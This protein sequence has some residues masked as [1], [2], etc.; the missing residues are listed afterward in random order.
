VLSTLVSTHPEYS[1]TVLLRNIPPDFTTTY[2]NVKILEGEYDSREIITAAASE[3]NIVI[4]N[5]NS[6]HEPSINALIAGLLLQSSP[7]FL[8]HLG[9]TGIVADWK[10][11]THRGELN[12]KIWSDID[13]IDA[14]WNLP[15]DALHRNV[16]K[17]IQAAAEKH[18]D[19][20]H[21][22]IICPPDIYGQG[23]GLARNQ[24]VYFPTLYA[25]S[26]KLGRTFYASSGTNT[27][28][29]V[30]ISDLMTVYTRLVEAAA[31]GGANADW[32]LKGYYFCGSQEANQYDLAVAAGKVLKKLGV[33]EEEEPKNC[34]LEVVGG[35]L[36]QYGRDGIALYMYAANSRT[37]ADRAGRVLGYKPV[38]PS[39]W[40][41]VEGD[42]VACQREKQR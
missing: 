7:T 37:R 40:E 29:W 27:R 3:A 42:L 24:S 21:T 11:D 8:L 19:K 34:S 25:E 22:A 2:P 26:S 28:S 31:N 10:S 9:G 36:G 41:C 30:H 6:D 32:G 17:I 15:D 14:I 38:G 39:I 4:H 13:D 20:L 23:F 18:G 12:P 35:M 5:G 16:D 1:I 33:V